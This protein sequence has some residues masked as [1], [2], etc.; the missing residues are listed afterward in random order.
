MGEYLQYF[1][2]GSVGLDLDPTRATDRGLCARAW[3]FTDGV[4]DDLQGQFDGIWCSN[5]LSTYSPHTSS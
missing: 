3:N 5:L 1:G 2:A 4:P